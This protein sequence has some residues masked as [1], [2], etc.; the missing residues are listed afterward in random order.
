VGAVTRA[1]W[2]V[3]F[4]SRPWRPPREPRLISV[5]RAGVHIQDE[6]ERKW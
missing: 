5:G 6:F 3:T 1:E 2:T 4:G